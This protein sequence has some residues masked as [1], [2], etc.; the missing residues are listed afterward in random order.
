MLKNTFKWMIEVFVVSLE[1]PVAFR[2]CESSVDYRF[3]GK[4]CFPIST[5]SQL[6]QLQAVKTAGAA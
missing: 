5:A 1:S 6:T 2:K 4:S 3:I